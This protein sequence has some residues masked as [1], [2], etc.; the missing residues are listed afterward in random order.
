MH[1]LSLMDVDTFWDHM[2]IM[3]LLW[4]MFHLSHLMGRPPSWWTWGLRVTTLFL[5]ILFPSYCMLMLLILL[6]SSG[7]HTC[8]HSQLRGQLYAPL[9]PVHSC[10]VYRY[11]LASI[12]IAY[13]F[14]QHHVLF[15]IS[16]SLISLYL[17]SS[18]LISLCP[19]LLLPWGL[20]ASIQLTIWGLQHWDTC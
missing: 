18:I 1:P 5:F 19:S 10:H 15:A 9:F 7:M 6:C 20:C 4:I 13:V 16:S 11:P 8:P 3:W 12:L 2:A 14:L 17:S